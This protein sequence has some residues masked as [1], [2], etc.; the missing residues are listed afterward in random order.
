MLIS[1]FASLQQFK[2][3]ARIGD[4]AYFRVDYFVKSWIPALPEKRLLVGCV[5]GD[6]DIGDDM[7]Y[8]N[9]LF[10]NHT[11]HLT[12]ADY[13]RNQAS[14]SLIRTILTRLWS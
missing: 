8:L 12:N 6:V 1:S 14:P 11:H 10:F 2:Y 13:P 7:K 9:P 4:D 5:L 3:F